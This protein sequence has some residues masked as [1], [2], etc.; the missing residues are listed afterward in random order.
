[1]DVTQEPD[2]SIPVYLIWYGAWGAESGANTY[3]TQTIVPRFFEGMSGSNYWA[4]SA[5]YYDTAGNVASKLRVAG[6]SGVHHR[7]SQ[8]KLSFLTHLAFSLST[9]ID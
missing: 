2:G 3:P 6:A 4:V 1:M 7:A 5:L 8:M 9:R